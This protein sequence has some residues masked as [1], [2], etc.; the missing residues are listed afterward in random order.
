MARTTL[1]DGMLIG[2][3]YATS[4]PVGLATTVAVILHEIPQ[5]IGDFGILLHAGFSK[6]AALLFNFL[7]ASLAI[8]G[9]VIS[10]A[11]SAGIDGFSAA[12]LPLTAGG[13]IYI[14]GSELVPE[15]QKELK[16]SRSLVQLIAIGSGVGLMLLLMLLE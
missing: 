10:L 2:A 4:L 9:A 14:A 1:I 7:S 11:V 6:R 16:P 13:F 12:M 8:V 15:L 3:S 5:E